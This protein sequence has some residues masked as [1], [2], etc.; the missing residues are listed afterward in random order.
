MRR[1]RPPQ[2][3]RQVVSGVIMALRE[4][5]AEER[6]PSGVAAPFNLSKRK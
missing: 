3:Q 1:S 6:M 2:N 4:N 5:L